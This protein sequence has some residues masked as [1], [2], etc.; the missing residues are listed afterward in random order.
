MGAVGFATLAFSIKQHPFVQQF[1]VC[2]QQTTLLI[3][4]QDFST[5]NCVGCEWTTRGTNV[6]KVK[7]KVIMEVI[8]PEAG[9]LFS[10]K[11]GI[12]IP[13]RHYAV[14]QIKCNSL[15]KSCHY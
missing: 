2:Q 8:E 1:I 10:I 13:P 12:P 14:T 9:T 11:K 6:L 15:K 5:H 3:L 7:H 4:G